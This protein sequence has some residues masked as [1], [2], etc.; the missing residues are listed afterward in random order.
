MSTPVSPTT[1][2]F[3]PD[4]G[5]FPSALEALFARPAATV[6]AM[7]LVAGASARESGWADRAAIALA[8]GWA[9]RRG[10][11]VLADLAVD[12]PTL[13]ASLGEENAEGLTDVFEFGLSLSRVARTVPGRGFRFVPA[14]PYVADAEALIANARWQRIVARFAE[15]QATLLVFVHAGAPGL[16]LLARRIGKAIVLAGAKEAEPIVTS[17]DA[18]CSIALVLHPP[19]EPAGIDEPEEGSGARIVRRADENAPAPLPVDPVSADPVPEDIELMEPGFIMRA[20]P[21]R[22][23]VSPVLWVL[24]VLALGLGGWFAGRR[25]LDPVMNALGAADAETAPAAAATA[26]A[27]PTPTEPPQPVEAPIPYSVAIEAHADYAIAQ[28][29]VAAL[30]EAEPS[31]GFYLA[32]IVVNGAVYYRVLAGPTVDSASAAALMRHLVDRGHKTGIADWDL[33]PT[34]WAYKLGDFE[35]PEAAAAR[36]ETLRREGVPT[37]TVE[38]PYTYGPPRYRLYAGAYENPAQAE[39][40]ARLLSSAGAT[41]QLVRRTGRPGA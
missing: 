13:H 20:P 27:E 17:L 1:M 28:E 26:P 32:P 40:M 33:R 38:V 39:V 4:A 3:D 25:Y 5:T 37:Y 35:T 24:L 36:A 15:D 8:T 41:A 9:E 23:R 12:A 22:R 19:G 34:I 29:R 30:R 10:D 11:I 31:I 16:D 2:S 18:A 14:G 6:P 21:R 7:L